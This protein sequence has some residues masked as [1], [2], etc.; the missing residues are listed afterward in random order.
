[1]NGIYKVY[2]GDLCGGC[3]Q[4]GLIVVVILNEWYI[5]F[6]FIL[7]LQ[8]LRIYYWFMFIL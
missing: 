2:I 4:G 3:K 5:S 7:I 6:F 1:M 8:Y